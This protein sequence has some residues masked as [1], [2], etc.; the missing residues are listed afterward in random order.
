[1]KRVSKWILAIIGVLLILLIVTC[2]NDDD[3]F[4]WLAKRHNISCK[5]EELIVCNDNSKKIDWNSRHIKSAGIF[6]QVEDN[7][8]DMNT[9]YEIRAIGIFNSFIDYST[10]TITD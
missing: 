8:S 7:Y 10:F 4:E 1:M 9:T 2:P 6:M 5:V 3:Y